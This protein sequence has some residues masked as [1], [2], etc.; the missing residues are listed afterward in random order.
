MDD[1]KLLAALSPITSTRLPVKEAEAVY[2]RTLMA[3][4]AENVK[5][6]VPSLVFRV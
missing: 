6:G 2:S 4:A 3:I 5:L 1:K